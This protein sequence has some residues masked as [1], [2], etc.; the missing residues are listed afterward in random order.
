[1]YHLA[2]VYNSTA[3]TVTLYLN[4]AQVATQNVSGFTP[5]TDNGPGS[6][7]YIGG[8]G[9]SGSVVG[10]VDDVRG[11]NRALTPAEIACLYNWGIAAPNRGLVGWWKFNESSGTTAADSSGNGYDGTIDGTHQSFVAGLINNAINTTSG[12]GG[13]DVSTYTAMND[14]T[15]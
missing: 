13:V 5:T 1:W 8:E 14:M 15:D 10:T 12:S 6:G 2:G 3:Q 7:F 4:G 9:S 11:Y